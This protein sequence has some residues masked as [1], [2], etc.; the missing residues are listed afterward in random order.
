M[1]K[2][3][4]DSQCLMELLFG[5]CDPSDTML[6]Y[7]IDRLKESTL[8][9]AEMRV[10]MEYLTEEE[11][12]ERLDKIDTTLVETWRQMLALQNE[13]KDLIDAHFKKG[14]AQQ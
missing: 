6:Q 10:C 5:G 3:M 9:I 1:S 2:L 13:F 14:G 4:T 8:T 7:L 11:R 12:R